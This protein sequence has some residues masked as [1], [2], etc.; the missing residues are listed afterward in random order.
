VEIG[1]LPEPLKKVP[2]SEIMHYHDYHEYYVVLE[3]KAEL[4][5]EEQRV[6]LRGGT[7]VMVEPGERHR[8]VFVDP[9]V[10]ARWVI[11]K[12]RSEPNSKHVVSSAGG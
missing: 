6:P 9:E 11:I 5:V 7:V 1:F 4:E 3:G 12:E 8:V 2:D 10:G